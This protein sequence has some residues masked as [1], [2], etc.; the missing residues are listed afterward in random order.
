MAAT[1]MTVEFGTFHR[2]SSL[3]ENSEGFFVQFFEQ[4]QKLTEH[5][6]NY[7]IFASNNHILNKHIYKLASSFMHAKQKLNE[8]IF[9]FFIC[10]LAINFYLK[11][12]LVQK[13][14]SNA[15]LI[16]RMINKCFIVNVA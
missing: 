4:I 2:Y 9:E 7:D 12:N 1:V 16:P 8:G 10:K 15:P 3:E 13:I 6:V 5:Y 14:L 11:I